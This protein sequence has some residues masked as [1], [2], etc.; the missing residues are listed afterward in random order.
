MVPGAVM[1][2]QWIKHIM[3][4]TEYTMLDDRELVEFVDSEFPCSSVLE[5]ELAQR[6][7]LALDKL[8]EHGL[9]TRSEG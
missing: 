7:A 4:K 2:T 8:D 5:L 3:I 1:R 6:L 9:N